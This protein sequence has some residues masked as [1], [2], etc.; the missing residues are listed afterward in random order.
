MGYASGSGM[1]SI[2]EYSDCANSFLV[3]LFSIFWCSTTLFKAPTTRE[4]KQPLKVLFSVDKIVHI[5]TFSVMNGRGWEA[6]QAGVR[7][8]QLRQWN[9]YLSRLLE[10]LNFIVSSQSLLP[11]YRGDDCRLGH[12]LQGNLTVRSST[13]RAQ[14]SRHSWKK[15]KKRASFSQDFDS[16]VRWLVLFNWNS[17]YTIQKCSVRYRYICM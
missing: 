13:W 5:R 14:P 2:P 8:R 12:D 4:R 6:W 11:W 16:D 7:L 10:S 17:V 1:A 9:V 15:K 3:P